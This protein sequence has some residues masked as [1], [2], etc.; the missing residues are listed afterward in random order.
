MDEE[1]KKKRNNERQRESVCERDNYFM[2]FRK[3]DIKPSL[4]FSSNSV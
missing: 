2:F 1:E 4:S 3:D